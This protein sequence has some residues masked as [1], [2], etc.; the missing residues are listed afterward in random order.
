MSTHAR[1]GLQRGYGK[2]GMNVLKSFSGP[3]P[4]QPRCRRAGPLIVARPSL[5]ATHVMHASGAQQQQHQ[6]FVCR[7]LEGGQESSQNSSNESAYGPASSAD[8]NHSQASVN[9]AASAEQPADQDRGNWRQLLC[10]ALDAAAPP[11]NFAC[12]GCINPETRISWV[13]PDI[14]VTGVGRLGLPLSKEQAVSLKAVA[15]QAPFGKGLETVVDTAV[16][17]ALQVRLVG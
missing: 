5:P 11:S 13:C 4:L 7:C 16:R 15:E 12:S 6:Y 9:T 3:R 1:Q 8:T 17:D 10:D 2:I 14:S